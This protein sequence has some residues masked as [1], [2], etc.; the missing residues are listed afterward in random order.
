MNRGA[1]ALVAVAVALAAI[2]TQ[3]PAVDAQGPVAVVIA[4]PTAVAHASVHQYTITVTGGPAEDNGT[5]EIRFQLQGENVEGG[6]PT[7]ERLL[8]NREGVFVANVTAPNAEGTV[9]L[10]VRAKS[11]GAAGNETTETSLSIDVFRP[12]DLRATIR[13]NGAATAL[14]VTVRFYVDGTAV[15]SMVIARIDAGGTAEANVSYIPVGL[16]EGR[17]VVRIEADMDGDGVIDAGEAREEDF[18]YKTVPSNVP[19]IIGTITVV[20]I[21]LLVLLLL[22]I[23]RQRRQG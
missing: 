14:N 23:R 18:F 21:A 5:F 15:G 17:H 9:S 12:V 4:G 19:A 22:A 3:L 16:A 13:N 1:L 7:F 8:S 2:L 11:G 10:F 6:D 20:L